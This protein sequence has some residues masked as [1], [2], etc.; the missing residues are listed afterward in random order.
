MIEE[1]NRARDLGWNR[2]SDAMFTLGGDHW[3]RIDSN[4]LVVGYQGEQ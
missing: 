4:E 2:P 3:V 1:C